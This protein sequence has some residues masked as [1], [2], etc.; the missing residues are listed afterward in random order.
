MIKTK[1]LLATLLATQLVACSTGSPPSQDMALTQA[2]IR[3]AV[4]AG[5]DE[6]ASKPLRSAQQ[7]LEKA[8]RMINSKKYDDARRQLQLAQADA[9]LAE[10]MAEAKNSQIAN[11]ELQESIDLMKEEIARVQDQ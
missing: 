9:E 11:S 7:R 4:A 5:A 8:Q 6:H 1:I 2:S 10:A 3:S